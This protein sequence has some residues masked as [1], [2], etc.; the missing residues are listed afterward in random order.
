MLL[1]VDIQIVVNPKICKINVIR[2]ES[3]FGLYFNAAKLFCAKFVTFN[4]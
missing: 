2:A 1:N 3:L 4:V